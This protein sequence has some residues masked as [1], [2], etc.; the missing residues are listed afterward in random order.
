MVSDQ[1]EFT[2]GIWPFS[3]RKV[4]RWVPSNVCPFLTGE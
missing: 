1:K 2:G 4:Y 3:K